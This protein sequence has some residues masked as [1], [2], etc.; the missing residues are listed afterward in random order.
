MKIKHSVLAGVALFAASI[1]SAQAAE[2]VKVE[3]WSN[4]LSPKFDAVMKDLTTKFNAS[5]NQVEAVWVDVAWD[6]FQARVVT[7]VA[8]GKVPGLVNLPKPWMDEFAQKKMIVP[9]T[10]EV[11]S[12]KNV[13]TKGALADVT[14]GN[15]IYGLPWYQVTAVLFYN[16]DLFSK[17]GVKEAPKS[18]DQLLAAAKQVKEKTG[19]SGFAPKLNDGFAGWFL[20]DGLPLIK[21]NKAV[22]NSPAHVKL[23]EKFAAAYKDGSIPKDVFKMGFEEQIAAYNSGKIAM[24][25]E[26]AH[27]LKRTQTDAKKIYEVTGVAGFPQGA[28]KTPFGGFLFLWSVPKGFKDVG[29]AVKLGQYLTSDEAQLAFAKAS[30]TFPSTNKALDDAFFQAGAKSADPVEQATAVAATNIKASRTLTISGLPDEAAMNKKLNDEVEAA[31]T[32]R[33][34]AKEALDAAAALWNEKLAAKK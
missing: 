33:K 32:G 21:D 20:Y 30:S 22:F 16:K 23:V 1:M 25:A 28:G 11:A 31:V 7:A 10:K 17:A 34:S 15:E 24:F 3:Y 18:L 6:A 12:F 9:V 8:S 5:Q 14:Y 27:A 19:V 4:S 2:K 13:Y 26:G 29:A